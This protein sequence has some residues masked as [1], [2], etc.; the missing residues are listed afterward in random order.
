[1]ER[2]AKYVPTDAE[3]NKIRMAADGEFRLYLEILIETGARPSEGLD[4]TW[5]DV[6]PGS[7]ILYTKKT[8]SGDRLPRR[9]DISEGLRERFKSWRRAQGPGSLYVFQQVL[10]R[11]GQPEARWYSWARIAHA[12]ICRLAEVEPFSVGCYR[13]YHAVS[14]YGKT[15][16][17]LAVQRRLGHRDIKTT[18]NYLASLTGV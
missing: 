17:V 8:G 7:V 3:V 10:P 15:K 6:H 5:E 9:V 2:R 1:M 13:H 18:Q 14:M 11:S 16:D 12:K 4:M